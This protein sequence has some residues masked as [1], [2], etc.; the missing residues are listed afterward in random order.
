MLRLVI[1]L[2]LS[3]SSCV[4]I[5]YIDWIESPK[6]SAPEAFPS[7]IEVDLQASYVEVASDA[8][9]HRTPS[10]RYD[11]QELLSAIGERWNERSGAGNGEGGAAATP[12]RVI[13]I[14]AVEHVAGDIA[15]TI[16]HGS[17]GVGLLLGLPY[18]CGHT[19]VT[20][21]LQTPDGATVI[22]TGKGTGCSG[23]YYPQDH[24]M[25]GLA[26]G[27]N[28]ALEQLAPIAADRL[29]SR[30]PRLPELP[31]GA[32]QHQGAIADRVVWWAQPTPSF[33]KAWGEGG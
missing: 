4:R 1:P 22:G 27:I 15:G 21:A 18:S 3:L 2:A 23:L 16:I 11:R 9:Q 31:N 17:T 33:P 24:L 20:L 13:L 28:D 32:A 14:G 10:L 5:D 8:G 26:D 25:T 12:V 19:V 30:V 7:R 6:A 29:K